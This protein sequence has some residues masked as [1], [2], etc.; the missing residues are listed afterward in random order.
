[1]AARV[2]KESNQVLPKTEEA[3]PLPGAICAQWIRCGHPGCKCARGEL[4]GPYYYR[5]Y[6]VNGRQHKA[7]VRPGDLDT[8][9]AAIA[10]RKRKNRQAWH[11]VREAKKTLTRYFRL[12][13]LMERGNY[14]EAA[15]LLGVIHGR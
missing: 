15:R 14:G 11:D 3:S 8:A 6:R 2:K 12:L 9:R 1:M 7:Y 13:A 4:H 5:F 10:E